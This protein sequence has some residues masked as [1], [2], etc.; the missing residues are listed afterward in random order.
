VCS[1]Q[2]AARIVNKQYCSNSY[3]FSVSSFAE[4]KTAKGGY[5]SFQSRNICVNIQR[6]PVLIYSAFLVQN[7]NHDTTKLRINSYNFVHVA[8]NKFTEPSVHQEWQVISYV[9]L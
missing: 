7:T 8:V 6:I 5:C 2:V 4:K 1:L 9:K 3:G